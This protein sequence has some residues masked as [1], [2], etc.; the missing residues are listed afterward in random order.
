LV[1][2]THL[3]APMRAYEHLELAMSES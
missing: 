3:I 1:P 2:L